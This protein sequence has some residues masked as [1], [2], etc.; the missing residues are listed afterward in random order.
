MDL[1]FL[2]TNLCVISFFLQ[3][4]DCKLKSI[5]L[6]FESRFVNK[7]IIEVDLSTFIVKDIVEKIY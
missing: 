4:L 7:S 6:G 2:K 1:A 5:S 3:S